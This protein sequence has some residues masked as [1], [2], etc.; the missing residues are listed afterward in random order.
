[1]Y[2]IRSYYGD[3]IREKHQR[4]YVQFLEDRQNKIQGKKIREIR[5][6]V[7]VELGN[8]SSAIDGVMTDW[9]EDQARAALFTFGLYIQ[10]EGLHNADVSYQRLIQILV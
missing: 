3:V 1:M 4:Y 9:E 6:E 8:V 10:T 5:A 2:A 7:R